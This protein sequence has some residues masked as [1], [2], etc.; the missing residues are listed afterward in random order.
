MQ[1]S[2]LHLRLALPMMGLVTILWLLDTVHWMSSASFLWYSCQSCKGLCLAVKTL[3]KQVLKVFPQSE[4]LVRPSLWEAE[5]WRIIVE[6]GKWWLRHDLETK[7]S[8][9]FWVRPLNQDGEEKLFDIQQN[10]N[11]FDLRSTLL[12]LIFW[13]EQ[14]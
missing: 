11:C 3:M 8:A 12:I 2:F 10:L 14:L 4:S 9:C 13:L 7:C 1:P 6:L 5:S